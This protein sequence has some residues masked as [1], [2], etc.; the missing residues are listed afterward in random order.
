[1]A[2]GKK[3]SQVFTPHST[4]QQHTL[5]T[6]MSRIMLS[7]SCYRLLELKM[8][9]CSSVCFF[10][11]PRIETLSVSSLTCCLSMKACVNAAPSTV[12]QHTGA[13]PRGQF[14][15][16]GRSAESYEELQLSTLPPHISQLAIAAT[17]SARLILTPTPVTSRCS[18]PSAQFSPGPGGRGMRWSGQLQRL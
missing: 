2:S 17:S 7:P 9:L 10:L 4:R 11:S 6:E 12:W 5:H 13:V 1:M 16:S 15:A 18:R 8:A 3:R 14:S